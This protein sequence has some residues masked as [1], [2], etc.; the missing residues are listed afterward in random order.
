MADLL[1]ERANA[2]P[3]PTRALLEAMACLAGRVELRVLQIATALPAAEVEQRLA[4]ALDD[5]LLVPEPGPEDAVRFRHDRVQESVLRRL[6]SRRAGTLR[7]RLARRLGKRPEFFAV[8]AELYLPMAD[9][10]RDPDERSRV[11]ELLDRAAE[12]AKLLS[13]YPLV[14]RLLAAAVEF[15]DPADAA[16]LV[17]L[18]TGRHLALYSLGRLDEADEVYDT[19]DRL[20]ANPVERTEA[21]LVQVSSLTNQGRSPQ[22]IA[23][24]VELLR[25]LGLA[26]P[27]RDRL[28][29]EVERRLDALY[30]WVDETTSRRRSGPPGDH[31][32]GTARRGGVD[33]PAHAAGVLQ[34]PVD[35]ELAEP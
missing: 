6:G 8:A 29:A 25:Q 13:N 15:A 34:R 28:D 14:E 26:V 5:G 7:L 1:A 30:R 10:V 21:T 16:T 24:G 31:R 32:S 11:A 19:I 18:H 4:P 17:R 2:M 3:Q 22:A 23:L 20:S 27:P 12:Q 33:Q 35:D 9:A